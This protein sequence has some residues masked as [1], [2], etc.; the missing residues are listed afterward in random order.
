MGSNDLSKGYKQTAA[1]LRRLAAE[2]TNRIKKIEQQENESILCKQNELSKLQADRRVINEMVADCEWTIEWLDSGRRPGNKRGI[3]RRA[4]YQRE[5]LMDPVRMQ[6]YITQSSAGSPVNLSDWQ[7]FQI[8]DALSRL[9]E[10][11]RECYV[12]AHGEC[13]SFSEIAGMLGVSKGSVEVYVTRAQK[14]I[15]MDLQSSLFLVG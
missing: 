6:A 13:F 9:S 5:K 10:R 14:K 15:S 1:M 4:A 3:E 12:L 8:E 7:R 2:K 11:E